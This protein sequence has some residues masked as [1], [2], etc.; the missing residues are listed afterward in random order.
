MAVFL[1]NTCSPFGRLSS[2]P[3]SNTCSPLC[4]ASLGHLDRGGATGRQK[5]TRPPRQLGASLSLYIQREPKRRYKSVIKNTRQLLDT[6]R[7]LCHS[8]NTAGKAVRDR[9]RNG[10][11]NRKAIQPRANRTADLGAVMGSRTRRYV[12]RQL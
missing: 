11:Q 7:A 4:R 6:R 5:T 9:E 12:T 8:K 10:K 1:S 2:P 3:C